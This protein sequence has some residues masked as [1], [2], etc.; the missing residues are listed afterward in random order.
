MNA[1]TSVTAS[2]TINSYLLSVSKGG[3]GAG[4]V[5]SPPGINCGLDCSESYTQGTQVTLAASAAAGS[6]F[7]GWS[8]GGC[9]GTGTCTVTM[10]APTSVTATFDLS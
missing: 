6:T 10:N 4:T 9:S 3:S 2:F 7:T 8:G 5:L 1:P